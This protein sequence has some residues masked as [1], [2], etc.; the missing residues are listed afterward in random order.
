M[1]RRLLC[2]LL[3]LVLLATAVGCGVA[4]Q[5]SAEE[6]SL[7]LYYPT[8][9][10]YS[11]GADAIAYV[12][13]NWEKLPQNDKQAQAETILAMLMGECQEGEFRSPIPAGTSLLSCTIAGSTVSVDFSNAYGQLS[14]MALTIAD[15]CVALSL[16]QIPGIYSARITVS[17]R[18]LAYRDTNRFMASDVLLSSTDDV[19][20]TLTAVLY[21]PDEEGKLQPEE[22]LLNLYE[23]E[24]RAG[25]IVNALL[26]APESEKLATLV[27]ADFTVLSVWVE[28]HS[29]HLNLSR[30]AL[31]LLGEDRPLILQAFADSLCQLENVEELWLYV[32]GEYQESILPDIA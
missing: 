31:N 16:T 11:Q 1:K 18:E 9:L 32:E 19:V 7:H 13:V 30:D 25:V 22:R 27:P 28:D 15:Y 20:R 24:T 3:T 14:G 5:L 12:D 4:G 29:C 8:L 23:G 17:G 6:N 10:D 26:S 2:A 21:F